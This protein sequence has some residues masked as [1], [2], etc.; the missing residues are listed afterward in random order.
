MFSSSPESDEPPRHRY[1][2]L[3]AVEPEP[4]LPRPALHRP[5]AG[6]LIFHCMPFP[7]LHIA[8]YRPDESTLH[9]RW[10]LYVREGFDYTV[11]EVIGE[12]EHFERNV[13]AR[14]PS[15]SEE[16]LEFLLVAVLGRDD[17]VKVKLAAETVPLYNEMPEWDSRDYV[18]AV[19][20][21][22]V[23][24]EVLNEEDDYYIETWTALMEKKQPEL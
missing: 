1:K 7:T 22:L 2:R 18:L 14:D 8:I 12:P 10:A 23:E 13:D 15:D 17:S 19:L 4:S 16:P 21:R 24:K 5:R 9:D 11:F 20:D 6:K 3:P